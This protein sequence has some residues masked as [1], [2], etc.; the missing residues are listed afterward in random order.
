[1]RNTGY[2]A[3]EWNVDNPLWQG[4]LRVMTIDDRCVIR[5]EDNKTGELF[6]QCNYDQQGVAVEPVLDSSRY[7]VLKVE[8]QG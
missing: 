8:D 1:M 5:L 2:R 7:F 3:A 6:A 4:R